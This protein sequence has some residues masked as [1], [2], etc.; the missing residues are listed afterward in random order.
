MKRVLHRQ[1]ED[2]IIING[3]SG[4]SLKNISGG[5][6][7]GNLLYVVRNIR[8]IIGLVFYSAA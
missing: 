4:R 2:N 8:E 6:G 7:W 1:S 5:L 3:R